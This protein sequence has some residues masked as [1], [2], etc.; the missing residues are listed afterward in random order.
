[1]NLPKTPHLML[2]DSLW[3]IGTLVS[4]KLQL[5]NRYLRAKYFAW[6][7]TTLKYRSGTHFWI[8]VV[9]TIECI[10]HF[11]VCL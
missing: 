10:A 2:A 11:F 8:Q 5:K 4:S 6:S 1:M 3:I 9:H 7:H